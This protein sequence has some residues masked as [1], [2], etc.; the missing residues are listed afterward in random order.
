[1]AYVVS[2]VVKPLGAIG[3]GYLI[4]HLGR[5][6]VLIFSTLFMTLAT[7]A[8]G[9]LPVS[10]MSMYYGAGLIICRII[11]GLSIS[12]E[13]S[14]AI[15]MSVEQ[16][17]K[18][19]AFSGSFA[20]V[21]GSVGLLLANLSIFILLYLVPHEQVIQ[22][23]WRIPFVIGALS[24]VILL[25][26]RNQIEDFIPSEVQV[27]PSFRDLIKNYKRELL[28]AFIVTNLS[29]SA[30]YITFIF[31]PTFLSTSLNLYSHKQSILITFI[32][33][34]TYLSAL[35]FAGILADKFG[36]MR[37]ITMASL[38]YLS[39]SYVVFAVLPR[40]DSTFCIVALIFSP[41]Y[42]HYLMLHCRPT[43][44]HSFD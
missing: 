44:S 9:L 38:L 32:A 35:P 8:I 14:S 37:Q 17:K 16:G 2:Y 41:S 13:Y 27:I 24:C 39:F 19:P 11:Q 22:Y 3:F 12:G 23:A 30:F 43:W 29:A 5:K 1:M 40:V 15:I 25:F 18:S 33:I 28:G 10:I 6:R 31:M 26:I 36:V 34:L 4:D 42:K 7:S 20:F 21:G